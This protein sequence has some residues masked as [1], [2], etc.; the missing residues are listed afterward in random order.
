MAG[1]TPR[2]HSWLFACLAVIAAAL[3]VLWALV[4]EDPLEAARR[5]VPLGADE[6]AVA[7]AVGR[8]ADGRVGLAG[9]TAEVTRFAPFGERGEDPLSVQFDEDGRAVQADV[10]RWEPTPWQRFL[11]WLG[12]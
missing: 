7:Q 2:P 6:E 8:P 1:R 5:R 3:A 9:K 10:Y 11:A 12:L 4:P